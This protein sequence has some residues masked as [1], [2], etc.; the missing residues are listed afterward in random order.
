MQELALL[1]KRVGEST[2]FTGVPAH[3]RLCPWRSEHRGTPN[4]THWA[5]DEAA[6]GFEAIEIQCLPQTPL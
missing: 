2:V 1:P 6:G 4:A 5:L 3:A